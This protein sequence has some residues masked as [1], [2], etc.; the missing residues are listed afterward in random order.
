MLKK[1]VVLS[2]PFRFL[3]KREVQPDFMA[4]T[5][6][7]V[8]FYVE[9]H[10]LPLVTEEDVDKV[11]AEGVVWELKNKIMWSLGYVIDNGKWV[12]DEEYVNN[13]NNNI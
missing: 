3:K 8:R 9:P 13:R 10:N 11:I 4:F 1:P 2:N 5:L 6:Y 7:D 12:I